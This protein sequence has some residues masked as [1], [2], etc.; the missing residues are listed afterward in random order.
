MW[1]T[2]AASVVKLFEFKAEEDFGEEYYVNI[3]RTKNYK[4][5]AIALHHEVYC[6]NPCFEFVL[7]LGQLASV[8]IGLPCWT[9]KIQLIAKTYGYD[10]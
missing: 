3:L 9:L 4:L 5:L 6:G 8:L 1:S 7:G 2:V 10:D